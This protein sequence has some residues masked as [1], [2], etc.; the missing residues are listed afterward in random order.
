MDARDAIER[1]V[2]LEPA[3]RH[4]EDRISARS[5]AARWL[6]GLGER[7]WA[8]DLYVSTTQLLGRVPPEDAWY[9]AAELA[10]V[11]DRLGDPDQAA[12]RFRA[13]A[14][15]IPDDEPFRAP[16]LVRQLV[17][18]DR[19]D[20]AWEVAR[21]SVEAWSTA[22]VAAG[23]QDRRDLLGESLRVGPVVEWYAGRAHAAGERSDDALAP[24][25]AAGE[26]VD[27][28]SGLAVVA[29]QALAAA[30]DR[31]RAAS[32][33]SSLESTSFEPN[34][35]LA[36]L[37]IGLNAAVVGERHRAEAARAAAIEAIRRR[38]LDELG[39]VVARVQ[40]LER[41]L[42][43]LLDGFD[44]VVAGC[45][46][47]AQRAIGLAAGSTRQLEALRE[48]TAT[49]GPEEAVTVWQ[50]AAAGARL[51][52]PWRPGGRTD[53]DEPGSQRPPRPSPG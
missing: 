14:D 37:S 51:G 23:R 11:L 27:P 7:T 24:A 2:E 28:R 45:D 10:V 46:R 44:G 30:G 48:A 21:S 26:G 36:W 47:E 4:V 9:G 43:G 42:R 22:L 18:A 40:R 32:L 12:R 15:D 41:P 25:R 3:L 6:L 8:E 53:P 35:A 1:I 19:V 50:G 17:L 39:S 13:L 33:A 20:L 29:V 34:E 5:A 49:L 38:P 31:A 52:H 16:W